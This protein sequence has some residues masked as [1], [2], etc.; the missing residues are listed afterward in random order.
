MQQRL[1]HDAIPFRQPEE[2]RETSTRLE[3]DQGRRWSMT[4]TFLQRGLQR[5]Q[6]VGVHDGSPARSRYNPN[7][8][9]RGWRSLLSYEQLRFV[10]TRQCTLGID[11]GATKTLL[12]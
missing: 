7:I 1:I 2:G 11:I 5:A 12:A 4:V 3:R 6:V 10:M 8:R 9:R